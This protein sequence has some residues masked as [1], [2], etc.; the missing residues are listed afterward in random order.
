M[1]VRNAWLNFFRSLIVFTNFV[2]EFIL[3]SFQLVLFITID[4]DVYA[5]FI[6]TIVSSI[7]NVKLSLDVIRKIQKRRF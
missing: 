1:S 6:L 5:T 7:A 3:F 4:F 2:I